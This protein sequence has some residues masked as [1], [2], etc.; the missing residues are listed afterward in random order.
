MKMILDFTQISLKHL[1][2]VGGKNASLGEMITKLAKLGIKVPPGFATTADAYRTFLKENNLEEIINKELKNLDVNDVANLE[3]ASNAIQKAILDAKLPK[4]LEEEIKQAYQQLNLNP[5]QT[6]AVRSSATA[7]DLPQASF[8]GQQETFLNVHKNDIL[9]AVKRVYASLFSKRAIAYRV[10]HGFDHQQIAISVGIQQMVRSDLACSGVIFTLDTE[11]GFDQAIFITSSYGLGETIVQGAVNP[12]EFY[13]H[14]PTLRENK[15][16]IISRKLGTKAKKMIYA[17]ANHVRVETIEV[18]QEERQQFSLTDAEI[19]ELA[20]QSLIIETHYGKPMDIEWAKDGIDQTLYIMQARPETVKAR[21]SHQF[22]EQYQL[23]AKV[24]PI[25]SGRSIGQKI[26]QGVARII[27]HPEQMDQLQPGEILVADMTDPDW[28]PI[29]KRASAIVTNRGGRTCHA[30][31]VA[32]E[33]GIPAIVGC[34][35]ATETIT[36]GNE[37]T[38]SCCEGETGFVYPGLLEYRVNRTAIENF[39]KLPIKICLNLANPEQAFAAQFLPNEGIG[40]ARVE[41]IISNMISIHPKALLDFHTLQGNLRKKI[42]QKTAAYDSPVEFYV[43]KLAEGIATIA[44]A[45]YPKP[46]I[47]RFSDFKSNEYANLLGGE[48]FEPQEENPMLGYRGASRYLS[49]DFKACFALE[50]EAIKR[51]RE[52]KGLTNAHV[53]FPFVRT[54]N[55]AEQL[56]QLIQSYGL[57]RGKDGLKVYM[58]CEIPSNVLLAEAFLQYFDGYS[59]G[60]ND[61]TQLALGL[62]RDSAL[63]ANLFDE[64]DAAVQILL[65]QVISTCKKLNKYIG[66]C[67]Q[68]PSDH[69]DFAKWL[70]AEGID[71]MSLSPDSV[72]QTWL[73]LEN[74]EHD[75]NSEATSPLNWIASQNHPDMRQKS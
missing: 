57:E 61:L 65:H 9:N 53:M 49:G 32:R 11:S 21:E 72:V 48:L 55:E 29:M 26:G 18:S 54:V 22:I 35:D 13:V 71:S 74:L 27:N 39:S 41:F 67:G 64:R 47:V 3:R 2:E 34:I 43:E 31:I 20:R 37:T 1:T 73:A 12:D 66:I 59:I 58:M 52:Q 36:A 42:Q 10:H 45:F 63:I 6:V 50:C 19:L 56:S 15:A 23:D 40:L 62:D 8:A 30:A 51:V 44:A 14:K 75:Q 5:N 16:A 69:L 7:E 25:C 24:K 28:E 46:I 38:V 17:K 4:L 33:L 70:V 60:S 68:A